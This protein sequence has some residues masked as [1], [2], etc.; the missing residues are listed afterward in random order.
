MDTSLDLHVDI[1]TACAEPVPDE[2]DIRRWIA[3]ALASAALPSAAGSNTAEVE[4]SLRLVSETEMTTLNQQYRG[5]SG[6]TNVLSF[7]ADLPAGVDH[8]LLGDIVI[9]P[10]VVIREAAQQG[11]TE[12]QHWA[13]MLVHGSLHLLGYD[14]IDCNEAEVMEALETDILQSLGCPS[15]YES[16]PNTSHNGVT[17]AEVRT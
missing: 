16:A 9:C 1:Q 10:A 15:P 12:S 11:K 7:P 5:K 13:H 17:G 6:P 14:H 4:L 2:D 3:A 8:P